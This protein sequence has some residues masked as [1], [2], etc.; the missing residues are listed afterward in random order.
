MTR[1][2]RWSSILALAA[3]GAALAT[4]PTCR[5]TK[6]TVARIVTPAARPAEVFVPAP[7][8]PPPPPATHVPQASPPTP[9]PSPTVVSMPVVTTPSAPAD[10]SPGVLYEQLVPTAVAVTPIPT[11]VA[12]TPIPTAVAATPIPTPRSTRIPRPTQTPK[13]GAAPKPGTYYEDEEGRPIPT[14]TPAS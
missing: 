4:F 12:A 5:S 14:P 8:E 1:S 9:P 10:R 11:A 6:H 13:A 7:S 3:A 2:R